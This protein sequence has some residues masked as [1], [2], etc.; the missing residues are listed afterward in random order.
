MNRKEKNR[1]WA[2]GVGALLLM[3]TR[4]FEKQKKKNQF[5]LIDL[6]DDWPNN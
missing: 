5:A 6:I 3:I 4:L 2:F 1:L